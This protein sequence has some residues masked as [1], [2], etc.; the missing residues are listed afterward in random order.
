MIKVRKEKQQQNTSTDLALLVES[1]TLEEITE[2]DEIKIIDALITEIECPED[3]AKKIARKVTNKIKKL[4]LN[5]ITTTLIRSFVNVE[6]YNMGCNKKLKS[7]S[8][9]TIPFYD[10]KQLIESPNKENGNLTHNPES[11]NFT[12]AERILKEYYLREELTKEIS[13]AHL[14]GKI[15]IHDAGSCIRLYCSGHSPEY[16]KKHG[17]KNIPTIPSSSS[18]ANSAW[19]LA[20][21]ICSLTQFFSSIFAG[22]I[23]YEAINMFFAPMIKG[24]D[25]KKVKQL[26][27]TLIFDLSQLAGAKGGQ[28]SFTDF[29]VYIDIPEHYKN[30]LAMG[31]RGKY[32]VQNLNTNDIIYINTQEEALK[33]ENENIIALR[34]KDFEYESKLFLKAI[35]DV[36]K[37]GDSRGLPFAFP[38]INMHINKKTFESEESKELLMFACEAISKKGCPYNIFDRNEFNISQ[39]CRLSISFQQ[40]DIE[41]L[42]NPE[43]LRFVG[44]QNVSINLPN[45]PL[46]IGQNEDKFYQELEY[47]MELAAQAHIIRRDYIKKLIELE[48]S[49]LKFYK[50]GM[51]G[52]PYVRFERGTYLIGIVGLN[53]CIKNLINLQLHE[54]DEAFIKGLEVISFMNLKCKE[55][56]NKYGINIK[57]EESP[58]EST[59]G[60]FAK[61]DRKK[62][63]EKAFVKENEHGI[64]Y[65]NSVHFPYDSNM[66]YIDRIVNQS[67][68]HPL[69]DA[70]SIIHIWGGE[71]NPDPKAIY[72]LIEKTWNNTQCSQWVYSPEF[73]TCNECNSTTIGLYDNCPNCKSDNI[74]QSTRIT[75]YYVFLNKFNLSKLAELKDRVKQNIK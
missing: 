63:K 45:I 24:W 75:G 17:I 31:K 71:K 28:I 57:L 34:Y 43:E 60:R 39:C 61:L 44:M 1:G 68:F 3:M 7:D 38:K 67:K 72:N 32:M 40:E 41:L 51:D 70:G 62:Y 20:R 16:I 18:P 74:V 50:E 19:V 14:E 25:Y 69:I 29:N 73:T 49:P 65:S 22:A 11:I 33:L 64:Y 12:L 48:D 37:E 55:L 47:R 59:A 35:L 52:K 46:Q 58:A 53:E 30:V 23:G 13:Q 9:V 27:Q 36:I 6:L 10:I 54:S 21:H 4:E 8:M 56:S 66:D 15:H 2:Y 5:T 26:A 42:N